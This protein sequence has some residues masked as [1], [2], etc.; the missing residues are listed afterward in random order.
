MLLSVQVVR[1]IVKVGKLI[2]IVGLDPIMY[3]YGLVTIDEAI[4]V[5]YLVVHQV[6]LDIE[7]VDSNS[8]MITAP[9]GRV[10]DL[11]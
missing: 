1:D 3:Y 10:S 6:D 11:E 5:G 4:V 8:V 9:L 2:Y 7:L